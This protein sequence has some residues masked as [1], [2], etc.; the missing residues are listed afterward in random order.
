MTVKELIAYLEKLPKE[1][2]IG[3]VH[4]MYS[5]IQVLDE[6]SL[7]YV[8]LV[9]VEEGYANRRRFILRQGRIMEYNEAQWDKAE[10]EPHFVPVLVLPG[11]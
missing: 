6:E 9:K 7:K 4:W 1:T 3:V 10:G 2:V 11:N 5:D 8:D